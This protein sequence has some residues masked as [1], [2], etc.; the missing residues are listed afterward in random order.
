MATPLKDLYSSE[1]YELFS[2]ILSHTLPTFDKEKYLNLIFDQE[3]EQKELKQRIHHNALVLNHF[4]PNDFK[5]ACNSLKIIIEEIYTRKI[6]GMRLEFMFF[7]EYIEIFGLQHFDTSTEAI[8]FITQ[9]TS[10]EFTVR[11]FLIKYENKMEAKML[12]WAKHEN[13]KVRRLATEGIR[14]RLPWAMALPKYKKDPSVVIGLLETLKNDE[15]DWVRLSVANNLND[16]SKDSPKAFLATINTWKSLSLETDK[17]I[18]HAS[19][20]LLKAG[21][22]EIL[23][24]YGYNT[25]GVEL[26]D[27][28]INNHKIEIGN[29]LEFSFLIENKNQS[30]KTI[31][32]EYALYFLKKNG[33]YG[34]KVFKISERSYNENEGR[35]VVRRHSFKLISTR[36]Y[37]SGAHQVAIII[38]GK[39]F[40]PLE[41][42]L[43]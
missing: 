4:L 19:R 9:F 38:N 41:F 2:D 16:I 11:P 13:F 7:P 42:D 14:P 40:S 5:D 10:C 21:H 25:K 36:N 39:E 27:F 15:S 31:R 34:R 1:F 28:K 12:E 33:E 24:F 30:P 18:K 23:N 17:L 22:S 26:S 43:L 3:W 29:A 35:I 20:T 6:E 37:N 8:E 32:I